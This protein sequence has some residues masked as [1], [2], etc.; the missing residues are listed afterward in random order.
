MK[1]SAKLRA[2]GR[3]FFENGGAEEI[4]DALRKWLKLSRKQQLQF[5]PKKSLITWRQSAQMLQSI[6]MSN[7]SHFA[8]DVGLT[9]TLNLVT[10]KKAVEA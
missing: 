4:A 1:F 10:P 6:L 8:L 2:V 5:V 3:F 9:A 7:E